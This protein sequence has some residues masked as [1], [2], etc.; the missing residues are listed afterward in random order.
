MLAALLPAVGRAQTTYIWDNVGGDSN[1]GTALNWNNGVPVS[2]NQ[3]TLSFAGSSGTNSVNNLGNWSLTIGRLEFASGASSFTLTGDNF[4]FNPHPENDENEIIQNSSATQT[5]GVG[6]FSFRY[7]DFGYSRIQ[8]NAGDLVISTPDVYLDSGGDGNVSK[9][10]I[11][12]VDDTRRTLT[13]SG[14]LW[15][16]SASAGS[17]P[18]LYIENNK[19]L[20]V[21]GGIDLGDNLNVFVSNGLIEFG[22]TGSLARGQLNLEPSD[23][24]N[25]AAVALSTAGSSFTA[26]IYAP[27]AQP[28]NSRTILAGLNTSGTVSYS[29]W[30]ES[31]LFPDP[32][33]QVKDIDYVSATGG[34]VLFNGA[35]RT[36]G[37]DTIAINRPDGE[38]TYGGTV[39]LAN[40]AIFSQFD[41]SQAQGGTALYGGTLQISDFNQ[42]GTDY[43]EF[44]ASSGDSGTFRYT[45]GSTTTT[46]TIWI[47]NSGIT[48]AAIDV[49]QAG[50]TLTWNPGGGT[51]NQNLTK[52]GAGTLE[53]SG[54]ISGAG[55]NVAVEEGTLVLSASNGYSGGT[56]VTGGT[57]QVS[58]FG[59]AGG[60]TSGLGTGSVSIGS[61]G[62]VT[63][64]LSEGGSHT[65]TNAFSLSG[66]TLHSEDGANTFS[67]A[68]A[69]VSGTSTIAGR[70][71]DTQTFSGG[72]TGTGNVVF[73]KQ[74]SS[75]RAPTF[76]LS[77]SGSNTGTVRVTGE[78]GG[79]FTK[80]QLAHVNALQNATLDLATGDTGVVEFTVGGTNTYSLGGLQGSRDLSLGGNT[81]SIGGN[82]LSTIYS[83][84]LSGSGGGLTKTG[85]GRLELSGANSYTGQ[86]FV[87][88]GE[89]KV[90]GSL[91]SAVVT[92]AAATTLS[93][94]GSL[95]GN[96]TIEG[97]HSPGNSPGI[98]TIGGDLT[99][100][101]SSSSVL[102]E[103]TANTAAPADRGVSYDGINVGGN[104]SFSAPTLLSL[105]FSGTG[106]TVDWNDSL[107]A[108]DLSGTNGWLLYDVAGTTTG[109]ENLAISGTTWLDAFGN[110]FA[111]VRPE[112]TFS[113]VQVGSDVYLQV[114]AV[115]EPSTIALIGIGGCALAA[116]KRRRRM[117][118]A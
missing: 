16:G 51:R 101:G 21:T 55:G 37:Y 87:Q 64:W 34:T 28:E 116:A 41:L 60:S 104:L 8:L 31:S 78:G 59:S 84:Q 5:I 105:S 38:T 111:D 114:V 77:A 11:A 19:R 92:T 3:T 44:N 10:I 95:G 6:A 43:F 32:E 54:E 62:Q 27:G 72:M 70:W 71:D 81:V 74:G 110:S 18:E 33:A 117:P 100:S 25:Q 40:E 83:G 50:T 89:L 47:D 14:N 7:G 93:G 24:G 91:A 76:V 4:G 17:V 80:L 103:L 46:K 82:G 57:L 29:G 45:G 106:S 97:L 108:T 102:W 58:D 86:T 94:T 26:D 88:A 115:P 15:E 85:A 98:Q 68:V 79:N 112:S 73:A 23:P 48:R 52:V 107:W 66:G 42:L 96:V 90:N 53:F 20:L 109:L 56:T 69:L 65:I 118:V 30:I 63:F 36:A 9:L 75:D 113:V 61:G 49:S 99:Y 2:S 12:G 67:G 35:L 1:W 39:I 22:G 13:L